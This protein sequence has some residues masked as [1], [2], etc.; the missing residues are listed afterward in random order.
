MDCVML[1]IQNPSNIVMKNCRFIGIIFIMSFLSLY[2][3]CDEPTKEIKLPSWESFAED[4]K[5]FNNILVIPEFDQTPEALQKTV[6]DIIKVTDQKLESFVNQDLEGMTY[7]S[8]IA[9]IDDIFFPVGLVYGRLSITKNAF[10]DETMRD[11]AKDQILKLSKWSV[12]TQYRQDVYD[13]CKAFQEKYEQ[14]QA[15]EL[16]G[17]D[18]KYYQ[19][20]MR[21]F[22]RSGFGLPKEKKDRVEALRKELNDLSTEFSTNITNAKIELVFSRD[23]L[24]GFTDDM[25][26]RY[27]NEDGSYTFHATV[28]P[29]Y[30]AI[31][32]NA[33]NEEVR[34]K[35]VTQRM[36]AAGQENIDL[37]N[38]I[39]NVRDEI[40]SL[41][42]Y[43]TWADYKTEVRM[44]KNRQTAVDFL[45][46]MAVGL[47]PK[48]QEELDVLR[49]LKLEDTGNPDAEIFI[50]DTG[51]YTE[52]LLRQ[53]YNIDTEALRDYFPLKACLQG[54]YD[55]YEKIFGVKYTQVEN[56][57]PWAEGVSLFMVTDAKTEE[58]L[59]MFYLD[60]FPRDGKYNHFA[61]FGIIDGKR[62]SNGLYQRPVVALICNFTPPFEDKPSLLS[63]SEVETLFHEFGHAMH[64][65]LT[66]AEYSSFSCTSVPRDFV[67]APS[68]MLE[69][70]VK[71]PDIL[72]SF[73]GHY[74][75]PSQKIDP[76][77]L[78]RMK[79]AEKATIG[80]HYRR[81]VVF[82][83]ADLT[84][85]GEGENK[86]SN[87][88]FND[89]FGKYFLP[90]PEDTM[91]VA[92]LGHMMGY[93]AGYYG[94][95]WADAIASDME[96]IFKQDPD[97]LMSQEIGRRLRDEIYAPGDSR[98]VN[99]SIEAFL[100][101]PRSLEPFLKNLGVK[102]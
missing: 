59:G 62:L 44:A 41:L 32:K 43:D 48:F 11:V 94:Y 64:S 17:E 97:G 14:G 60:L 21:G 19:E 70:W 36:R 63:H 102:E 88:I 68:Q 66:R 67:E 81:Q 5:K 24:E 50:W 76:E 90:V 46:N 98:D 77:I 23:E 96:E 79:E 28:T 95:A 75:D 40:G 6:D 2:V 16:Q 10:P 83:L 92:Y 42:G 80:I 13:T 35:M 33:R 100:G 91:F 71:E 86:D 84:L 89:S 85:H 29:E 37:L 57:S 56:P 3:G 101:R 52:Q 74:K 25:L 39:V 69:A 7:E 18:L 99:E 65:I 61:Q 49:Q 58:P 93:D 30:I 22:K 51:Y 15:R 26:R 45:E 9:A 8:S 12:E 1:L 78:N 87:K 47:E 73:A 20:T 27:A 4:A 38:K 34:K 31:M 72:N 53:K 54:M 82:G 55:I